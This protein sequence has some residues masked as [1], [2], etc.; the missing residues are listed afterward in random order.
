MW[1]WRNP[2]DIEDENAQL[3]SEENNCQKEVSNEVVENVNIS[4]CALGKITLKAAG[5]ANNDAQEHV[6]ILEQ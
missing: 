1:E 4:S 2:E 5:S 6:A 3:C